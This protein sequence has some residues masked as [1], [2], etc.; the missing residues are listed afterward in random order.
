MAQNSPSWCNVQPWELV[1]TE[2]D[3]TER[4][5]AAL[6]EHLGDAPAPDLPFPDA[7]TGVYLERR[8]ACAW[9]LYE[10]V[11]VARGDRMASLAQT[12]KNF[13]FFGA[14]HVAIL[15]SPSALGVYGAVDCGI[16]LGHLLLAAQSLGLGA[17]AQAAVALYSPFLH[18]YFDIPT[19]R[20]IVCAVA[21]GYPDEDHPA[22]GFKTERAPID[23]VVRWV[24]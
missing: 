3:A 20:R 16:Y 24:R 14:P 13:T 5:R 15:T 10:S 2:G 6:A 22:N 18:A 21:L 8:R 1:I 12:A 17:I 4:L 11:G 9:Q 19:E 7:Y 23:Q